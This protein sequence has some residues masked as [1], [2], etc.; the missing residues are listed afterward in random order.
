[1]SKN[2]IITTALSKSFGYIPKG[3][4]LNIKEINES[5]SFLKNLDKSSITIYDIT[6]AK[7]FLKD[8][9]FHVNDHINCSGE[10]PLVGKQQELGI[11]FIDMTNVYEKN[12]KGIITESCGEKLNFKFNYPSTFLAHFVILARALGFKK[13]IGKLINNPL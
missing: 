7:E 4:V 9:V 10:N 2:I 12:E 11:D 3:T 13:I 6:S 1:M 5:I 8:E